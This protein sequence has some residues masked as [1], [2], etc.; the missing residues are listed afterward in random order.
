MN[1]PPLTQSVGSA[2]R[3]MRAILERHLQFAGLS[4]SAWTILAFTSAAPLTFEQVTQRQID[5]HVVSGEDETRQS[6]QKL[7]EA[8][9]MAINE[10]KLLTH[11]DKGSV[12][13]KEL[14]EKVKAI[15]QALYGDL[16]ISDLEATHRTM[17]EIARRAN[18]ILS[19]SEP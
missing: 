14:S 9:L 2:E 6:I 5:G 1:A 15:T 11:T 7:T 13:F 8:G 17:L 3:S 18:H 16:P 4:F 10:S 12:L 19:S